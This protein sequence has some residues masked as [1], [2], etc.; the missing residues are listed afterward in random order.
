M[1][2]YNEKKDVLIEKYDDDNE[3]SSLSEL[4]T[5]VNPLM[6]LKDDEKNYEDIGF[7]T[8]HNL[9]E[10]RNNKL[11]YTSIME[12]FLPCIIGKIEFNMCG[13]KKKLSQLATRSDEAFLLLSLENNFEKWVVGTWDESASKHMNGVWTKNPKGC[14]DNRGWTD[15]GM[16]RFQNIMKQ[17]GIQRGNTATGTEFDDYFHSHMEILN[18]QKTK[19]SNVS[20][21]FG[22]TLDLSLMED[23]DENDEEIDETTDL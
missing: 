14:S 16:A 4:T 8:I 17:V 10:G 18:S 13:K 20:G 2:C 12:H 5:E 19:V 21:A 23:D 6:L 1:K 15:D 11:K 22:A 3:N 7:F 9:Q